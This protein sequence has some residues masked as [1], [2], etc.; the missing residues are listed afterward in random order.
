MDLMCGN[1][2]I[3]QLA[4][5]GV[6]NCMLTRT[7]AKDKDFH[8]AILA[9]QNPRPYPILNSLGNAPQS[10]GWATP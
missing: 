5:E 7:G 4:C 3:G 1:A 10:T 6:D 9:G 2:L 8:S